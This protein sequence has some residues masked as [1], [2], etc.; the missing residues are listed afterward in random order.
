VRRTIDQAFEALRSQVLSWSKGE[1]RADLRVFV[2]PPEWEPLV[3]HR[4]PDLAQ[5][6]AVGST[7]VELE[8]V[9]QGFL[10]EIERRK[11]LEERLMTLERDELLHDL[12]Q[13][14]S[15]YLR[16][17]LTTPLEPPTVCR[18]FT[19]TGTLG[20]F[21][22]YSSITN[23]LSGGPGGEGPPASVLA[24]PG[25]ADERSLNLLGLRVDTNYRVARI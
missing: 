19:N 4:I 3:L 21:V 10:H 17:R 11:G 2:Y 8:D 24:F 25:E 5:E 7:P 22:S 1:S 12:G 13:L 6:L 18:I 14:A 9:G 20:A 16:R 23:E 15:D